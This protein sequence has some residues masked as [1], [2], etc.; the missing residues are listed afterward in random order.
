MKRIVAGVL[1]GLVLVFCVLLL[2]G[3]GEPEETP[4]VVLYSGAESTP[5]VLV[6]ETKNGES[7]FVLS[8]SSGTVLLRANEHGTAARY[9]LS[10]P[11][12]WAAV[13][14]DAL[15]VLSGGALFTYDAKTLTQL[16][17]TTLAWDA[18]D[19]LHFAYGEDGTQYA[20]LATQRDTLS[21]SR[22]GEKTSVQLGG[23]VES[24]CG[25][26]GGVWL[27]AGGELIR[28]SGTETVRFSWASPLFTAFQ[29][30]L[31]LDGDGT[32]CIAGEE[33][34][35]PLLSCEQELYR[36]TEVCFD[37]EALL[38]ISGKSVLR[39]DVDEERSEQCTL[40][41]KALG[42]T[43]SGAIFYQD[44]TVCYAPFTFAPVVTPTP[45][46]TPQ[47]EVPALRTEGDF[48][49]CQPN[50]TVSEL[51][52][53][54]KPEAAEIRDK[55]GRLLTSGRLA[56]GMTANGWTVVVEG[57]CNGSGTLT[58]SDLQQ[59][60]LMMLNEET[61]PASAFRAIDYDESGTINTHDL[62]TLSKKIEQFKAEKD[63]S[64]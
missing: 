3:N 16:D 6:A 35:A 1:C 30:N 17:E 43:C 2:M 50:T 29:E 53:S 47:P 40:P 7:L 41:A 54:M 55:A 24:F 37:G 32:L 44:D 13:R 64:Q 49:I 42:I 26:A 46:P 62:L 23:K 4:Y 48:L 14:G 25:Y 59:A 18:D 61:E 56:T 28:Q 63:T 9:D 5:T 45:S 19:L 10:A 15:L 34:L 20:V 11:A 31:I 60:I 51:R 21:V 58:G 12:D 27:S 38:T 39:T 36:P 8:Q 57:D 22:N 33:D 52:E